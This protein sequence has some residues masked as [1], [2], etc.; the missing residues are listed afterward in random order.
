M[1]DLIKDIDK[2]ILYSNYS[3]IVD[4]PKS[5]RKATIKVIGDDLINYYSNYNNILNICS[6]SELRLLKKIVDED[7][8][9]EDILKDKN[10]EDL[11]YKCLL[12]LDTKHKKVDVPEEVKE[13]IKQ[14]YKHMDREELEKIETLNVILVGLFR[15][16]GMLTFDDLHEI[17]VN[18]LVIDKDVLK[19]HL[20]SNKYFK[21]YVNLID[22]KKKEYYMYRFYDEFKDIIYKGITSLDDADY[23]LRP[24]EEVVYLRFND[25][26]EMNKDIMEMEKELNKHKIN[27]VDTI[28]EIIFNIVIDDDRKELFKKLNK[29]GDDFIKILDKAMNNMPSACLKGYTRNEYLDYLAAKK[30][31]EEEQDEELDDGK[32]EEYKKAR[33]NAKN[34]MDE[35]MYFSFKTKLSDRFNEVIKKNNIFFTETD[36]GVVTNLVLF[37]SIDHEKNNFELFFEKKVNVFFPKYELF[38]A[39]KDSYIEGIFKVLN[40]DKKEKIITLRNNFSKREYKVFDIALSSNKSIINNYIYTS[41]V[42]IDG[43]TF[44]TDY[45]LV[46]GDE[47]NLKELKKKKYDGIK[48]DVCTSFLGSYEIFRDSNLSIEYNNLE[49]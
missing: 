19:K 48:S 14:A 7:Y 10:L 11:R 1:Y 34:V 29:Y 41:I 6:Y 16:Y 43:F 18:Y 35:A 27:D 47:E 45:L 32:I 40:V 23:F 13:T 24:F 3:V 42:T 25:F 17:L 46:I 8:E 15:I 2:K 31:Y 22:Y 20:S 44:T 28:S 12:S 38:K 36:T 49:K 39:F 9:Y 30:K 26:Y 33:E 5:Y 21:F 37:H 4:D